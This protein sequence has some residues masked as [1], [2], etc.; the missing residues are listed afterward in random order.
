MKRLF[1][2]FTLMIL[3]LLPLCVHAQE[4]DTGLVRLKSKRTSWYL[5]TEK[6]GTATTTAK[7]AAKLSQVWILES[8]GDGYYLRS[9]NTG[10]YLQAEY[11]TPAANK[12]RLYIRKSPNAT[13]AAKFWNISSKSDFS[14]SYF[15]N[16]NTSYALFSYSMD[17][18]CD[19]YIEAETQFTE[20][21]V[22]T[23]LQEVT[24]F[25]RELKEGAY[26]RLRSIYG[27]VL[28]EGS[29]L[30]TKEPD[31]TNY[32]QYWQLHHSDTGWSIQAVITQKFILRQTQ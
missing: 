2:Y 9:A 7:N 4:F 27:R 3:N 20:A 8:Y 29:D 11:T 30:S 21:D 25:T 12:T 31:D 28:T 13:G 6:N 18:G 1:L 10:E 5:S 24:H 23:R 15:L 19:W 32:S 17:E 14:G 26:Y 22:M 16:T